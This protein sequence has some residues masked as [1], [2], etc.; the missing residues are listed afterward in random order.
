MPEN[1]QNGLGINLDLCDYDDTDLV[2]LPAPCVQPLP[3]AQQALQQP[4]TAPTQE[5]LQHA[6]QPVAMP[7]SEPSSAAG[8]SATCPPVAS[9]AVGDDVPPSNHSTTAGV[10]TEENMSRDF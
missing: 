5:L 10:K 8:G 6:A 3:M 4:E 1:E 7:I 9:P 2:Q